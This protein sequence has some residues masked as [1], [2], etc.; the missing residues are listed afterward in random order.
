MEINFHLQIQ[1]AGCSHQSDSKHN[2]DPSEIHFY[3]R[4]TLTSHSQHWCRPHS[5]FHAQLVSRQKKKMLLHYQVTKHELQLACEEPLRWDTPWSCLLTAS[6]VWGARAEATAEFMPVPVCS[7]QSHMNTVLLYSR[8]PLFPR[9][10]GNT[11]RQTLSECG[12]SEFAANILCCR[13]WRMWWVSL[14]RSW[15]RVL[16]TAEISPHRQSNNVPQNEFDSKIHLL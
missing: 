2:P 15:I 14:E 1:A 6:V 5:R 7:S 3:T 12:G 16:T 10:E 11:H 13:T 8:F 4:T 9:K